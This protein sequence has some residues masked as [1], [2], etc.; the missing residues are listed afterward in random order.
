MYDSVV[1]HLVRRGVQCAH[2]VDF[3]A[4]QALREKLSA[5]GAFGPQ[6]HGHHGHSAPPS[7]G[8]NP[9]EPIIRKLHSPGAIITLVS[10][11]LVVLLIDFFLNYA[12]GSVAT[13]LAIAEDPEPNGSIRL[14]LDS[15]DAKLPLLESTIE[16]VPPAKPLTSSLRGTL[17]HIRSIGGF[18]SFFRG[19]GFAAFYRLVYMCFFGVF[20][21]IF[22]SV[23]GRMIAVVVA[24]TVTCNLHA[25]WT[26][27]TVAADCEATRRGFFTRFLKRQDAKHLILPNVR[28]LLAVNVTSFFAQKS[29]FSLRHVST[30]GADAL[31]V[32]LVALGAVMAVVG[33]FFAVIPAYIALIRTELSL[34]PEDVPAVV[35]FDR[36]FGGRFDWSGFERRAYWFSNFTMRGAFATF[37]GAT[38]KRVLKMLVKSVA[39]HF[40]L[41]LVAGL[42]LAVELFFLVGKEAK[43]LHAAMKAH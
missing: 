16:E 15:S 29:I 41:G 22:H 35:S 1:G 18:R 17:G 40:A 9:F 24:A 8:D 28:Y 39:L 5:S 30:Q 33:V 20:S 21:G 14:P 7:T 42:L 31:A 43:G 32:G 38:Y 36:S 34:L 25:A 13:N 19:L 3:K 6:N 37:D 11:L 4:I 10:T 27:A 12:I 2:K 26:H 23:L